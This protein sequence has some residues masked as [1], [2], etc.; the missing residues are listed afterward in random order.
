[1]TN[2]LSAEEDSIREVFKEDARLDQAGHRFKAKS[3]DGPNALIYFAQLRDSIVG[4]IQTLDRLEILHAGVLLVRRSQG[5]PDD[6]PNL[7]LLL[8]IRSIRNGVAGVIVHRDL[9]D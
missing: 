4:K 7:M 1:M 6:G 9:G 2:V 5:L 8:S 3:A